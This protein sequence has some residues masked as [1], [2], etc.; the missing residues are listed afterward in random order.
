VKVTDIVYS[1][2]MSRR[3]SYTV[4]YSEF[5]HYADLRA[6]LQCCIKRCMPSV[7]LSVGLSCAS[8]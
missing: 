6:R 1:K 8:D 5:R 7:C 3:C 2:S 4:Y